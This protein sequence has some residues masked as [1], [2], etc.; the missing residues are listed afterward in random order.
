MI[1]ELEK[2]TPDLIKKYAEQAGSEFD[3]ALHSASSA[4]EHG[5]KIIKKEISKA[6]EALKKV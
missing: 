4:K 6:D 1:S 3:K 2:I 5:E